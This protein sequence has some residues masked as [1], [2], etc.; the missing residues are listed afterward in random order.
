MLRSGTCKNQAAELH[1]VREDGIFCAHSSGGE[2][3]EKVQPVLSLGFLVLQESI[4]CALFAPK[5]G[6][7]QC[8]GAAHDA[9][10]VAITPAMIV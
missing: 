4:A 2:T 6:R 8:K 3:S 5:G 1:S 10:Q 7:D 9:G